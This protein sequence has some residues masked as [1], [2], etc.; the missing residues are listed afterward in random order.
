MAVALLRN[1][2][3]NPVIVPLDGR[4]PLTLSGAGDATGGDIIP[5]S[6]REGDSP[7]VYR[8]IQRGLVAKTTDDEIQTEISSREAV[9]DTKRTE[10]EEAAV[11][12]IVMDRAQDR[13]M[14]G[15]ACVAPSSNNPN[16]PCGSIVVRPSVLQG[17]EPPLCSAHEGQS[18]QYVATEVDG[19]DEE[20]LG[21]TR[22]QWSRV[23]MGASRNL[24]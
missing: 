14:S 13:D 1:L 23:S 15:V 11:S 9:Q 21:T 6:E 10:A 20:P 2:T 5:I 22:T 16:L 8:A 12:P 7:E 24:A 17:K 4:P 18:G 19:G 3:K